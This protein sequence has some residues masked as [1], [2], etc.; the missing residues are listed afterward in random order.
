M[1]DVTISFTGD[2]GNL[3]AFIDGALLGGIDA[4]SKRETTAVGA[5]Q[6]RLRWAATGSGSYSVS[7]TGD[8][9]T[10]E[11]SPVAGAFGDALADV[12]LCDFA[13]GDP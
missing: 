2:F 6:H 7:I 8:R 9:I 11:G 4:T 1:P 3:S 10:C 12:G 5:G 13:A